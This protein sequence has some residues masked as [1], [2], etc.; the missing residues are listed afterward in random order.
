MTNAPDPSLVR[1]ALPKGRMERS[2]FELLADAGIAIQVG[3]RAY[4]PSVS[5]AGFDTKILKPQNIVE[6]LHVGSRDIGFA[7]ADWV[8]ELGVEVVELLNTEFDPVRLVAAA[9]VALLQNGKLPSRPLLAATEYERLVT[10]WV[11]QQGL[12]ARVVRTFGATEVFPPE[13]ADFIVD[14]AASGATLA[15]NGLMVFDE[16]LKSSTRLF[17]CPRSIDDAGKRESI[18]RFVMLLR[19]VLE[20]RSRVM[21]EVNVP[22]DRL[23]AIVKLLP[24]MREPTVARLHGDAGYAVKVAILRSRLPELIPEVKRHGGTDIVVSKLAQSV[25]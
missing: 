15:A 5:L 2:V 18:E 16:L 7:G 4:R 10:D 1:L 20:A 22:A 6:M 11:R 12:N 3:S 21:L 14:V 25:P 9:P 17:A 13:D 24:C 23:E 19:S 8:Q